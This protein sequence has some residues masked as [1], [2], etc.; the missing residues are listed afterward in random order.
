MWV[1][2]VNCSTFISDALTDSSWHRSSQRIADYWKIIVAPVCIGGF[3]DRFFCETCC[4]CNL[5]F[6]NSPE[7]LNW[8]AIWRMLWPVHNWN[9]M[10]VKKVKCLTRFVTWCIVLLIKGFNIR[11]SSLKMWYHVVIEGLDVVSCSHC[12]RNVN[13][14]TWTSG[15]KTTLE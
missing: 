3:N 8:V 1:F 13:E 14:W 9:F 11:K 15:R 12:A 4:A 10:A 6:E 5:L 7:I 2:I